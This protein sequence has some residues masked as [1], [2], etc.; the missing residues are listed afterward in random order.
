M[1]ALFLLAEELRAEEVIAPHVRDT[2]QE[3]ALGMLAALGP[4]AADSPDDYVLLFEAIREG[5]LLHYGNPRLIAGADPDL[6]LLAGD[7]LYALGLVRLA[8]REDMEAV[9]ELGDLISLSA[10]LQARGEGGRNP[11][12]VIEALWLA[13]A[14]AVGRGAGEAHEGAKRAARE[15]RGD[16]EGLL[17]EAALGAAEA[18]VAEGLARAAESVGFASEHL[19]ERG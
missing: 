2:E 15:G 19:P 8:A 11:D 4:R 10:Q 6:R 18:G 9:R 3:P 12:P 5:Y 17:I 14:V 16:A 13:S 1:S 7:Y